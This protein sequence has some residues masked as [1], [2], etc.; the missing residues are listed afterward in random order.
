VDSVLTVGA[1]FVLTKCRDISFGLVVATEVGSLEYRRTD[2]EP[3]CEN[4]KK[5]H[6]SQ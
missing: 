3:V 1:Y 6:P 4:V 5:L 2:D